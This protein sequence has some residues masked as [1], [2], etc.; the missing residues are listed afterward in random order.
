MAKWQRFKVKINES[1]RPQERQAIAQ[2]II[3]HIVE[4]SQEKNLDK[5]GRRF[6]RYS[7][8][9]E[10]S[11]DFKIAGK[12]AGNV[13]LT[14]SGEMLNSIRLLQSRRGE[15]TIGFDRGDTEN[16]A[17]AEGNILGTYGKKTSDPGKAR[18]FLGIQ[19]SAVN[20]I[21]RRYD[22][23]RQGADAVRE[24]LQRIRE[25]SDGE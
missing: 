11:L 19:K 7:K 16:N 4:R 5:N 14:L 22:V 15:L 12:S 24:R 2:E 17:K 9:Y 23:N 18:D 6:P 13:N 20:E 1:F 3:D 25:L 8:S 21:Q 10:K